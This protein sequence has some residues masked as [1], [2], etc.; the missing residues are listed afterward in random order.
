MS[1]EC[2]IISIVENILA[3][4]DGAMVVVMAQNCCCRRSLLGCPMFPE[5]KDVQTVRGWMFRMDFED[6]THSFG[7]FLYPSDK[8]PLHSK[9]LIKDLI[10]Y[11]N[12]LNSKKFSFSSQIVI[13]ERK[14]KK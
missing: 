6:E 13:F 9:R 11:L 14:Q 2:S 3:T 12:R 8:C 10:A 4:R 5:S 1:I 7:F